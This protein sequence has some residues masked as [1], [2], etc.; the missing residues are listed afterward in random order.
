MNR[1]EDE[2]AEVMGLKAEKGLAEG[3]KP[4][5]FDSIEEYLDYLNEKIEVDKA[6]I[7]TLRELEH[8]KYQAIGSGLY[9]LG[10]N[11]KLNIA[12]TPE[13]WQCIA[14]LGLEVNDVVNIV[15]GL[16]KNN[17][18]DGGIIAQYFNGE[19]KPGSE[20]YRAIYKIVEDVLHSK[21]P[22]L[23]DDAIDEKHQE[24]KNSF[25]EE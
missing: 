20:E 14:T 13:F 9:L 19:M 6:E 22:S 3:I 5:D 21:Y 7:E 2:N 16:S 25:K 4:D 1:P 24:L 11:Q 8:Y 10:V 17:F 18:G 12:L 23:S 15:T